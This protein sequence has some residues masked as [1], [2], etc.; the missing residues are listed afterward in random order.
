M[1]SHPP[2]IEDLPALYRAILDSVAELER[3]G[4]RSDAARIRSDATR[5]YS[6]WDEAGRRRLQHLLNRAQRA[7]LERDH[8]RIQGRDN[9]S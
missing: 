5:A 2:A 8:S 9:R 4:G 1:E 3:R 7:I 6:S